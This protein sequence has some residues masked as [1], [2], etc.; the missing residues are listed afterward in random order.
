MSRFAIMKLDRAEVAP[1][2]NL[3]KADAVY[4]IAEARAALA[5]IEEQGRRAY[6]R[7]VEQGKADGVAQGRQAVARLLTESAAASQSYWAT[8]ERRL[9]AIVN[10]AV[11][12]IVGNLDND[13]AVAG[14]VERLVSEARDEGKIRLY[15]SPRQ[16]P[17]IEKGILDFLKPSPGVATVEVVEDAGVEKDACRVETDLGIVETSV[18]AQIEALQSALAAYSAVGGPVVEE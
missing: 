9:V 10:D 1:L 17:T 8:S 4:V 12:R 18:E 16:R 14:M 2:G 7:A 11:R 15:V 5:Q 3:I 6:E 13:A